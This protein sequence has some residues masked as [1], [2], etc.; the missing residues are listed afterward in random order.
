MYQTITKYDFIKNETIV[1]K[2]GINAIDLFNL[3]TEEEDIIG[4]EINFD[5]P[6]ICYQYDISDSLKE[7]LDDNGL[8]LDDELENYTR[9]VICNNGKV[10]YEKW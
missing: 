3:L 9:F 4:E 8:D 1:D 5:A 2:F 10:I 6:Q 7:A